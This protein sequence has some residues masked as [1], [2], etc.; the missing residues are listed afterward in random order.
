MTASPPRHRRDDWLISTQARTTTKTAANTSARCDSGAPA[1]RAIDKVRHTASGP[2]RSHSLR[3]SST[4]CCDAR[5][6][7]TSFSFAPT[8]RRSLRIVS[9]TGSSS[10]VSTGDQSSM[11]AMVYG[12]GGVLPLP[13]VFGG[14]AVFMAGRGQFDC[15]RMSAATKRAKYPR[16]TVQ[17]R[18]VGGLSWTHDFFVLASI[19]LR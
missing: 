7:R 13:N 11:P 1:D 19:L 17:Q 5:G 9:E 2:H 15:A 6:S 12:R 4:P 18:R 16:W 14:S 8:S 10:V 3:R